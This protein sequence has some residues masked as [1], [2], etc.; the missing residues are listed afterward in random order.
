MATYIRRT[1]DM[2]RHIPAKL[3]DMAGTMYI[4]ESVANYVMPCVDWIGD[5]HVHV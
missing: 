4:G 2:P 3:Y 5:V 1:I